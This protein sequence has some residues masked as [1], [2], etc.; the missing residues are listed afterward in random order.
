[1]DSRCR[2]AQS[3]DASPGQDLMLGKPMPLQ[4]GKIL[5]VE[6]GQAC[7]SV[8]VAVFFIRFLEEHDGCHAYRNN[9]RPGSRNGDRSADLC[10]GYLSV[11]FA[12]RM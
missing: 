10:E 4:N 9:M 8:F 12:A 11:G 7:A 5:T 2:I 3:V 6:V 1:M